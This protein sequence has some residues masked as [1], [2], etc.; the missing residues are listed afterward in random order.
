MNMNWKK[1]RFE[2]VKYREHPTR[3]HGPRKDRYYIIHYRLGGKQKN[4]AIG[5][6]SQGWTAERAAKLRIQLRENHR[7]GKGPQTL[8]ELRE[9]EHQKR[10]EEVRRK[11]L[12]AREALSFEEVF[13]KGYRKL[14]QANKRPRTVKGEEQ[15][16]KKWISPVLGSR[17]LGEIAPGDIEMVKASMA[18]SGKAP[19]SIEYA[20]AVI[21]Q[22]FNYAI[23]N[24]LFQGD[25]PVKKVPKPK[26]DN[27]R[28][29]FL[30]KEEAELLLAAL[31]VRSVMIHD[32]ALISLHCGLRW[33][34]IANL[35][36]Q[37]INLPEGLISIKDAKNNE[38]RSAFMTRAVRAVF[39]R[40]PKGAPSDYV[41]TGYG[42][43]KMENCSRTFERTVK[44]LKLNEGIDDRRE[45]VTFHTLRHT[46]GSW[47]AQSGKVTLYEIKELMGHKSIEMT[48]RYSHLMPETLQKSVAILE[49]VLPG[50]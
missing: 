3:R 2:G 4:E 17:R 5:W 47:L 36:W 1:T 34:E 7:T 46:Y 20:L 40:R 31:R 15:L 10:R 23:S 28:T 49:E 35:K 43:G 30:K 6:A 21:R 39:Q 41:F 19:R 27:R 37:D 29:R 18:E 24:D 50:G 44:D 12:G 32:M 45:K 14:S 33:G 8:R 42:N 9:Q 13:S 22:V 11:E 48:M 25:N 38:S 26:Y 16:F